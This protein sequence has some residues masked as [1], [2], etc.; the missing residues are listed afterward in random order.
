VGHLYKRG[1]IYWIK[2]SIDGRTRRQSTGCEREADARR[3]LKIREGAAATGAPVPVRLD[4][5]LYDEVATDLRN[6]YRT[7]ERRKL[8][9]VEG[10]LVY[11]DTFFR[12]H[13][14][15]V[16]TSDLITRYVGERQ[17]QTTHLIAERRADG[18]IVRRVTSNRTINLELGLLKRMCRLA[19]RNN[20][21]HRVP[22][23]DMLKEAAPREGFF[24]D[25]QAEAVRQRLPVDLEAAVA[26]MRTYGW[27]VESEVFTLQR[28]HLD[29]KAGT[30][31]LDP[32]TTKNSEGRIVY[33][34]GELKEL[35]SAQVDRVE[36]LS[37][38]LGRIVPWLFPHFTGRKRA[39]T[40]RKGMRKRW[41][42]AVIGAG[43][44]GRIPHD[45]RR[46][47]VRNLERRGVARSVAMK[48]TG[49]KTESVYRRYAIVSDSD[50]RE[51]TAKLDSGHNFGHNQ[52]VV[53]D[54]RSL[55]Q[56]N[57]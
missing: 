47:A 18:T 27:R 26:I 34:T 12:G 43:V 51:A 28:R 14:M 45:W 52:T 30:L 42:T 2:L 54:S 7:T 16:I 20:K 49:H 6:F 53:V 48:I 3:F 22:P 56:R 50:L 21:L 38:K 11:L 25:H 57:S 55:T 29:L 35:L 19:Y 31:R 10:R 4:R 5:I 33:L 13:R 32:G 23:I 8:S 17:E 44:P 46:T 9:E 36:R 41:Q 1:R 39:G 24:E 40:Q 15:A 37:K